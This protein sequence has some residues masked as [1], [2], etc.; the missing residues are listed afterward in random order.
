MPMPSSM[1]SNPS[2][3]PTA[4]LL[5]ASGPRADTPLDWRS[6][7]LSLLDAS[8]LGR[9]TPILLRA[10]PRL[11]LPISL[12]RL[13]HRC[14]LLLQLCLLGSLL[15]LRGRSLTLLLRP[16]TRLLGRRFAVSL[17]SRSLALRA[18]LRALRLAVRNALV[19][20]GF[21][22]FG[23]RLGGVGSAAG[24]LFFDLELGLLLYDIVAFAGEVDGWVGRRAFALDGV[25]SFGAD[26]D[27]AIALLLC[28]FT[29]WV[30]AAMLPRDCEWRCQ[31]LMKMMTRD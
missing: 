28:E 27:F 5:S 23:F 12:V 14:L 16:S 30:G 18:L 13:L 4:Y 2:H 17:L 20:A 21:G 8:P 15:L 25:P 9:R 11:L 29:G 24:T 22:V 7:S 6:L 10:P 19:F 1:P 31:L 26:G 3:A